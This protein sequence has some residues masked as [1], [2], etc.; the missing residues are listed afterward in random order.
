MSKFS[1]EAKVGIFFLLALA[2][3]AFVWLRVLEFSLREGYILK[4]QF[5]SVEGLVQGAQVQ[6]AGIKVGTVKQINFDRDTGKAVVLVELNDAYR[7]AIPEDSQLVL[8][9]KGLLGDK[10]LVISPGRP[11][12]RKLKGGEEFKTVY[13]P[14]DTEKIVERFGVISQD[15]QLLAQEARRQVVTEKG[16]EK[17]QSIVTNTEEL[18]RILN[19]L[20]GKNKTKIN[21]TIENSE[22]A[23]TLINQ[24]LSRNKEKI[25]R[26]VDGM[27]QFTRTMEKSGDK[28]GKVATELDG[29]VKEVRSG[30]GTLGKLV[31]DDSLHRDVQGLVRQVR[32]MADNIQRGQGTVGRLVTDPELYYEARRA[33][34]NMNK[35]AED[36][37]EATPVSTLA[38]ILGSVFK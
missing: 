27:E 8:K 26:S 35:T 9:T 13:E 23:A 18:M 30:K 15:L 17:M 37:S 12:A 10:Y 1:L 16:S 21:T 33:I 20:A 34:R 25:D 28:F 7:N 19:E 6:M 4:A 14:V 29:L 38:I 24:L 32:S 3:F 5:R 36:I 11:N 2:I 31:A 22:H